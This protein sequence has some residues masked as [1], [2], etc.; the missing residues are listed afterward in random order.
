MLAIFR[1]TLPGLVTLVA[2][3]LSLGCTTTLNAVRVTETR[4][5]PPA[6][7]P[8]NLNF[9]QYTIVVTRR[10]GC[11]DKDKNPRMAIAV[12]A[13]V[14][15]AEV[16]DPRR[17]YVIDM[18]SLQSALKVTD[19][20][21][22]YYDSGAL[23]SVNGAAEDRTG[24]ILTSYITSLGKL[25]GAGLLPLGAPEHA[26]APPV[27]PQCS[28]DTVK[29]LKKV[30]ALKGAIKQNTAD[31]KDL[32][33]SLDRATTLAST[34]GKAWPAKERELLAR[35]IDALYGAQQNLTRLNAELKDAL[36][37]V[38]DVVTVK[39]PRDGETLE[40]TPGDVPSLDSKLFDDQHWGAVGPSAMAE[41]IKRSDVRLRIQA[42]TPIGR[43][44]AQMCPPPT[45]CA[46]DSLQGLKYRFP[47]SGLFLVCSA[48]TWPSCDPNPAKE[49]VIAKD[50]G[51]ISQL[52]LVYALPLHSRPFSNKSVT[53]TFAES[54]LPTKLGLKSLTASAESVATTAG[55]VVDQVISAHNAQ[56]S[57]QLDR[58]KAQTD[59]LKAQK[60]LADAKKALAPP[61][62]DA[63]AEATQA[64]AADTT[65]AQAELANIQAHQ[66]LDAAKDAVSS[67]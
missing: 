26:A 46:D 31:V 65:L 8:Y 61:K 2:S 64:F 53:A 59:L 14:S 30:A 67:H 32:S 48:A 57:L 49:E 58:L 6:G 12:Q 38:S 15:R 56:A 29:T 7:A 35:Q 27:V 18:A 28:A 9:T 16:R 17:A 25:V 23:K 55:N 33:A 50:E 62:T 60:D 34:M 52:G 37:A 21:V 45:A 1:R 54:G 11:E 43:T 22:E 41:L 20:E 66:A 63:Q 19:L 13:D 24:P 10:V 5:A 42:T 44:S 39:W 51:L 3:C 40:S 47:A 4:P 36:E